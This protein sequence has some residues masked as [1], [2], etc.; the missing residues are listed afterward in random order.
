MLFH[1]K[2]M[3]KDG[4][5][6]TVR[7]ACGEAKIPSP[8]RGPFP[9]ELGMAR[10]VARFDGFAEQAAAGSNPPLSQMTYRDHLPSTAVAENICVRTR[11]PDGV[12]NG[13]CLTCRHEP[14]K[15][16]PDRDLY[17]RWHNSPLA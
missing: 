7:V 3:L 13:E 15:P 10:T 5:L 6:A 2:D 16:C 11:F 4:L 1:D 12:A 14:V 8:I 17:L 9:F